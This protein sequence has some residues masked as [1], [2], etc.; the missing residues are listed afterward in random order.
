MITYIC[1]YTPL[2]LFTALGAQMEAPNEEVRDFS[3]ADLKIHS[4]ICAHARLLLT[5]LMKE[6]DC[7]NRLHEAVL[8]NC[9]DSVRRVYDA[10]SP[11]DFDY[12]AMMDLPHGNDPAAAA[13]FSRE[14]LRI[15]EEY[16][17]KTGRS[18]DRALF[19]SAWKKNAG[20]WKRFTE[21]PEDG[22]KFIAVLG[23]RAGSLLLEKI[24]D[25]LG[26]PVADLTCGGLRTLAPP[27]EN[28]ESL[29]P[30]E[31]I[32]SY[33]S[34][35]LDQVPCMR[36]ENIDGRAILLKSSALAGIIYHSVKFCDY[37]SFEYASLKDSTT[38]PI[39]KIETDYTSQSEGQLSTRIAAFAEN[40]V[41]PENENMKR[42]KPI[43]GNLYVGIDS[44]STTTNAAVIDS[45]GKLRASAIVRTGA[46]AAVAAER[47]LEEV[48]TQLGDEAGNITRIIATGYG[49]EFIS[50]ADSTK[51]EISC[52]AR[53]AHAADPKAR[54]IIDIGGQDSKVIC[55]DEDGNVM[56][57]VMN[58]KC[59]AGTGRFLEM[60]A[61]TLELSLSEMDRLS[62]KWKKDLTIS[63]T[64]TVF[65]ESEVVSMIAEN[66][67]AA[68]IIHALDKAVAS[69]TCSMVKRTGGQPPFMM[70]GGVANNPGVAKEI[71]K[72]LGT[73]LIIMEHPDLIGAIGAAN[74]A[75]GDGSEI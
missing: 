39:L 36:M 15:S 60:M 34:A 7:P 54:T 55:L 30:D 70:T 50:F 27:P 20:I 57:F 47:A 24:E 46:K 66:R 48:R 62:L 38:L 28:A 45:S 16:S 17:K 68:D 35:L 40:L 26:C 42:N 59:A 53:G 71:E 69:K 32:L 37:Y 22:K 18:F 41:R 23:A 73:R 52:H 9:C 11:S 75:L 13:I 72:R 25:S 19:L 4:S 21:N 3:E 12:L 58:D 67:E 44:G 61:Q 33:A 2:E 29:S 65:A 1:K 5:D 10:L 6:Q 63:S 14:L 74:F 64:C 31:L 8:T 56:N 49:R 43:S 51:T